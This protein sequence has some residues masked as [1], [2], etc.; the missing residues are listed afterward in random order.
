MD[1]SKSKKKFDISYMI[2]KEKLAFTK[3]QLICELE[4]RHG[5]G[6]GVG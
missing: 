4:E 3:V 6:L 5:V 2:T 1:Q